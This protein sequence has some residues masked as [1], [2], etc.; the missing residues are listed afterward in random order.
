MRK[1]KK[2]IKTHGGGVAKFS[3]DLEVSPRTVYFWIN[4]THPPTVKNLVKISELT[5]GKLS[6]AELARDASQLK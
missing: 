2:W 4:E 3:R 5:K 1:L 6:F